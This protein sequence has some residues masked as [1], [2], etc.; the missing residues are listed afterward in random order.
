MKLAE[1]LTESLIRI[2]LQSVTK[3]EI[4]RELIDVLDVCGK[5]LDKSKILQAV[6]EREQ[7]MST[8]IGNSVAIPH[9]KSSGV[10]DLAVALG[11]TDHDVNFEA[12]DGKPVRIVF[13]LVGPEKSSSAH[14]KMLSRIS[15][16]LNQAA[17]RR[18]L[19]EAHSAHDAM[20]IIVDEEKSLETSELR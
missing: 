16:L 18:K 14:I 8:G 5:I 20:R 2:P 7:M 4:I 17:F 15:R 3:S 13:M 11:I 1:I 10:Q 12:L 9:G 6:L 19:I